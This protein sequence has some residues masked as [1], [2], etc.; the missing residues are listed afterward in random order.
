MKLYI[1]ATAIMLLALASP[2]LAV[3]LTVDQTQAIYGPDGKTQKRECLET[4]PERTKCIA[5]GDMTVGSVVQEVLIN[6]IPQEP[7]NAVSGQLAG[8][9]YGKD[10]AQVK[11]A[12]LTMILARADKMATTGLLDPV[13][14]A[15][16][17]EF[18]EP[19]ASDTAKP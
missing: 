6:A 12:D 14:T 5:Y 8:R 1:T 3:D 2:A 10:K 19:P 17:H 13:A 11:T 4:N 18:L 9:L 15:R 16:L 7:S